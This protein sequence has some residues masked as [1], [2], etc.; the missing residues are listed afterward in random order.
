[1]YEKK[2]T[3]SDFESEVSEAT[4]RINNAQIENSSIIHIL[5]N[6]KFIHYCFWEKFLHYKIYI[7]IIIK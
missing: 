1:M 2:N 7:I 4:F 5:N 6:I 3:N